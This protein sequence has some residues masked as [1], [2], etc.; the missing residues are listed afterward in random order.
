MPKFQKI[1]VRKIAKKV[2]HMTVALN[3]ASQVRTQV[4]EHSDVESDS[5]MLQIGAMVV[6][7]LVAAQTDPYTNAAVDKTADWWQN[8]KNNKNEAIIIEEEIVTP[9]A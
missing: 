3:V 9:D 7:E 5:I 1:P 4:T 2:A 6:G 8:R